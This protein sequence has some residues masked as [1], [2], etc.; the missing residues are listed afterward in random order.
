MSVGA[1]SVRFLGP[2]DSSHETRALSGR[3]TGTGRGLVDRGHVE[4]FVQVL[5][6]VRVSQQNRAPLVNRLLVAQ[7]LAGGSRD[8]SSFVLARLDPRPDTRAA[9]T[10][11]ASEALP[12]RYTARRVRGA[13]HD[14]RTLRLI[15]HRSTRRDP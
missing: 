3:S 1:A 10:V 13:R 2:L 5:L 8:L 11:S 9:A 12:Q 15:L 6:R 14:A 4:G 7:L